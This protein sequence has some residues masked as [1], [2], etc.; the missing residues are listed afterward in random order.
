MPR[1]P[2]EPGSRVLDIDVALADALAASYEAGV[3]HRDPK[4]GG[5]AL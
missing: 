4:P 2:V 3:V 1:R 5:Q